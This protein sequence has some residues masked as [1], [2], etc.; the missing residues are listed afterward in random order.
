M[1]VT[2]TGP[3]SPILH[4]GGYGQIILVGDFANNSVTVEARFKADKTETWIPQKDPNG[5]VITMDSNDSSPFLASE[6]HIR[7][8]VDGS[9]SAPDLD[10][11][12]SPLPIY[13]YERG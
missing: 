1:N 3:S 12:V 6:C 11:F 9:G 4:R 8:N 2:S 10:F 13:T 7:V 5:T